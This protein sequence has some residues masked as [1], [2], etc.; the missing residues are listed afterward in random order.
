[1]NDDAAFRRPAGAPPLIFGHRGV[2]GEAPENTMAAFELA[3]ASG[4]DGVEL[5]V[6]VCRSGEL[7]GLPRCRP[8][9]V[10]RAEG[11]QTARLL[12]IPIA[13]SWARVDVGEGQ[14]VPSLYEVLVWAK[15]CGLRVNVEMKRDVPDCGAVVRATAQARWGDALPPVLVSSFDPWMLASLR[16]QRRSVLLGY[17]FA[18]D[19]RFTR[20]GWLSRVLRA[21]AVHPERNGNRREALPGL[22]G[23]RQGRQRVDGSMM[24]TRGAPSRRSVSTP[25]SPTF[26]AGWQTPCADAE[27]TTRP[28]REAFHHPRGRALRTTRRRRR[29]LGDSR[30]RRR[31]QG[32][33]RR[34]PR[35]RG[36]AERSQAPDRIRARAAGSRRARRA[37]RVTTATCATCSTP[38]GT[39][40]FPMRR[41]LFSSSPIRRSGASWWP[42]SRWV[43]SWPPTWQ[44]GIPP[45]WRRSSSSATR[46]DCAPLSPA[47][48]APTLRS[49]APIRQRFYVPKAGADIRDPE[50]R[51]R[52]L[53]YDVT[54]MKSA[55]EV[56]RAGRARAG[57]A[58][59]GVVPDPRHSRSARPGLSCRQRRALCACAWHERCRGRDHAPLG[60][61]RD[62]RFRPRRGRSSDRGVRPQSDRA[63]LISGGPSERAT[64]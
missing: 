2:R 18:S 14:P 54:P 48:P 28:F 17:L 43:R 11:I 40:G 37:S 8:Y 5:D 24:S 32:G 6:R 23:K 62:R 57:R 42:G 4:A 63:N 19:Q 52:H 22:E 20:S 16:R 38:A 61:H 50:A 35:L 7:V 47:L 3:A 51:R 26:R 27:R 46:R 55:V 10:P 9:P 64:E 15:A 39:I 59:A 45:A 33:A 36:D 41:P 13:P 58:A 56:L 44:R 34:F 30:R 31:G 29:P 12:P 1:M 49:G 25:S 60:P 21:E 53:T